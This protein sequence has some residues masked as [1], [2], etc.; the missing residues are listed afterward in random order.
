MSNAQNDPH[1]HPP[2]EDHYGEPGATHEPVV[3][4]PEHDIDAKSAT[5]WF[6]AG[7]LVLFLSL[8]V[9]VPIFLRVQD[10]EQ[11][12]KI[13]LVPNEEYDN[14]KEAELYF[15]E[16]NNPTRRSIDDVLQKM[17]TGK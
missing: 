17:A 10:E 13:N 8:W 4:D 15:L 9:M 7:S 2:T 5:I 12:K 3:H 6:V 1:N 14:V 16:G 11:I